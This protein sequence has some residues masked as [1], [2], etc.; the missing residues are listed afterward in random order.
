[1][2]GCLVPNDMPGNA[3]QFS[4][5]AFPFPGVVVE[6]RLLH[7]SWAMMH[8][9]VASAEDGCRQSCSLKSLSDWPNCPIDVATDLAH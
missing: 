7:A 9:F 6:S 1:M 2:T 5:L 8:A 4:T 3:P